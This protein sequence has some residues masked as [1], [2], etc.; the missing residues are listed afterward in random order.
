MH[1]CVASRT[2]ST[3]VC[4][5]FASPSPPTSFSPHERGTPVQLRPHM[6]LRARAA[7]DG[8]KIYRGSSL[9]RKHPPPQ[10]PDRALGIGLR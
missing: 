7:R 8:V 6:S 10:D 1:A 4:R 2:L 3:L 9:M 5:C